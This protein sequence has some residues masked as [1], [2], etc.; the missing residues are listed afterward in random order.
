MTKE[1]KQKKPGN[2]KLVLI[3]F[4]GL[5]VSALI[6]WNALPDVAA[7]KHQNPAKTAFMTYRLEHSKEKKRNPQ[8][9][10]WVPLSRISPYLVKAVII[11]EDSK[12]WHHEGF[13]YEGI[14][15]A[16]EKD[17]KAK[18]FRSGGST[19]TQQLAKNLYLSPEKSIFRK[20]K[21]AAIT[22]RLEQSLSKK[23]ILELYLN[24]VEWGD[25]IYGAE[26]ASRFYFSKT[27]NDLTPEEAA[28][29]VAVL[30]NPHLYNPAGDQKYVVK[31]SEMIYALMVKRGVV[32]PGYQEMIETPVVGATGAPSSAP[33]E[34]PAS[35]V[36]FPDGG[37]TAAPPLTSPAGT[38]ISSGAGD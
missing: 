9:Q 16:I 11:A 31:R 37:S 7:L 4:I 13:D 26:A 36:P 17:F 1:S 6:F 12:F 20:L 33:P 19:I 25:G 29:L 30:P 5:L 15:L 32:V 14:Q 21:E 2:G 28:R 22:L 8:V 3:L 23:R 35:P 24:V 38:A 27:S 18:K 10:N 34:A